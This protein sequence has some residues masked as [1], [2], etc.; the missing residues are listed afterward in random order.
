MSTT[1]FIPGEQSTNMQDCTQQSGWPKS[2]SV[3]RRGAACGD[4]E[5]PA[6]LRN[7]CQWSAEAVLFPVPAVGAGSQALGI[8]TCM[9]Y[10]APVKDLCAT[11]IQ[12]S[13][14][15]L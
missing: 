14:F 8:F 3:Q 4:P 7:Y 1:D 2:T 5:V 10:A 12:N 11:Q 13:N 6:L 9:D 15:P